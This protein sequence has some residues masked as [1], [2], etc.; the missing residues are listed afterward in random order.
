MS[1][2][3]VTFPGGSYTDP[4]ERIMPLLNIAVQGVALAPRPMESVIE[5]ALRNMNSMEAVRGVCE[6]DNA[7]T[8]AIR[9][10]LEPW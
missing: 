9:E 5:N 1:V 8:S 3:A 4:A 10:S 7:L 2:S 6:N